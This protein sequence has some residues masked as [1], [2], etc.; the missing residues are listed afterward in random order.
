MRATTY[1]HSKHTA[2][3]IRK[4]FYIF[5]W[6]VFF[7]LDRLS[8]FCCSVC[9]PPPSCTKPTGIGALTEYAKSYRLSSTTATSAALETEVAQTNR[10]TRSCVYEIDVCIYINFRIEKMERERDVEWANEQVGPFHP[11]T[12]VWQM[13]TVNLCL[14]IIYQHIKYVR[15][16]HSPLSP[17]VCVPS[18]CRLYKLK[19][20]KTK[21]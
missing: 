21:K 17:C 14:C 8:F 1:T 20:N 4:M 10:R 12:N 3:P 15:V 5:A 9:M 11:K 16:L 2:E 19:R 6:C 13:A 18:I 7:P